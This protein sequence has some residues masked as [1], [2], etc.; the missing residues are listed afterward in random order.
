MIHS[1]RLKIMSNSKKMLAAV[2]LVAVTALSAGAGLAA[3]EET[4]GMAAAP[5]GG[6]TKEQI[7]AEAIK[8]HP[9]KVEKIYEKTH[10]G[11]KVWEVNIKGADGKKHV[12]Y[13]DAKTGEPV[14]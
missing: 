12:L 9:G 3:G 5:Y 7:E 1:G 8:E 10:K 2:T 14:K 13:Y 11:E 6:V 4:K